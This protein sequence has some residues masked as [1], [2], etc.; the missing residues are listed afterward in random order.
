LHL[1]APIRSWDEAIPLGNGMMGG[2]LWGEKNLLRMSLDRGDLWD[3]RTSGEKN[4]WK[5]HPWQSEKTDG[6]P[7]RSFRPIPTTKNAKIEGK[8]AILK[9]H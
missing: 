1:T 5:N 7:Q 8:T 3:E 6:D 9:T 2:L 4:W